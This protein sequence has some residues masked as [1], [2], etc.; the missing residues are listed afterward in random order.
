M[1]TPIILEIGFVCI[2]GCDKPF[3]PHDIHYNNGA[4]MTYPQA[5]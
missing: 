3:I 4:N 5:L 2:T 1:T